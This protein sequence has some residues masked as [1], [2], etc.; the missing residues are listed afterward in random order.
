MKQE[1]CN[2]NITKQ[3]KKKLIQWLRINNFMGMVFN[4]IV[5]LK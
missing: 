4:V 5:A 3:V 2:C 1:K